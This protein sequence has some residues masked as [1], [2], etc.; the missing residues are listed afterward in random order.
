LGHKINYIKEMDMKKMLYLM[1][2]L[3]VLGTASVNAQVRIGGTADPDKSAVLDLNSNDGT[4]TGGL[5]LPRV[6]LTSKTQQLNGAEPKPGTVVYNTSTALEGE[7]AYVWT[8]VGSG[9]ASGTAFTGISVDEGTGTTVTGTGTEESPLK[10]DIATNGVT[11][12]LIKDG[13]VTAA[14]LNAMG[15]SQGKVLKYS[16][17]GWAPETDAVGVTSVTGSGNGITVTNGTTTPSLALP[18]GSA[19]G[20]VL[21]YDGSKWVAGTDNDTKDGGILSMT[22]SRGI[23]ATVSGTAATVALPTGTSGQVLKSD[24][25]NWIAGAD[26]QGVTAVNVAANGLTSTGGTTPTLGLPTTTTNGAALKYNTTNSKWEAGTDAQ[27]VTSVTG[28]GNGITVTNGTTTP[29]LALPAGSA[30]GQVLKYDGSKW[31]AGTDAQGVTAVNVATNGLTSTGGAS[32]TIGLPTA[33]QTGSVLMYNGSA[34]QS[35][36][37]M[38]PTVWSVSVPVNGEIDALEFFRYNYNWS[39]SHPGCTTNNTMCWTTFQS[40]LTC[41]L[42]SNSISILNPTFDVGDYTNVDV[43]IMCVK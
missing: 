34:W 12:G 21:K 30:S 40:Y 8:K 5:A 1:L 15:A 17:S 38:F 7:G 18:A 19:S 3:M 28:S 14:K 6:E 35:V 31:A 32:P 11:T 23:T 43:A 16:A 39:T 24:G 22:G 42:S 25:T 26:A 41:S 9:S 29:S 37:A 36:V 27:G 4:A 33:T 10:V 20:Q 2:T 13:Q